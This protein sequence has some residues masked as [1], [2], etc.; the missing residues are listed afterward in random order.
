MQKSSVSTADLYDVH[1]QR[2]QVCEPAFRDFGNKTDFTGPI[3]T[4]KV[5]EDFLLIKQTLESD[6]AGCVLV[7]D[8]GG[9]LRCAMIGD[10]L[11]QLALDNNWVGVLINGC[12]RDSAAIST[13]PIGVKALATQ[14]ARP[15]KLGGGQADIPVHF[16]GVVFHPGHFLYADADGVLLSETDLLGITD[17]DD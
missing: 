14:P 4:L 12:L 15:S 16:A 13:L 2:V 7:I 3:R 1:S 11:A 6:G 17:S 5:F 10:K 8:G 9:S